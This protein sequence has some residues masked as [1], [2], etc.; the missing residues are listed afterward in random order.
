M[1]AAGMQRFW[2]EARAGALPEG[3]FG[4]LLDARPL[5][6]PSGAKL[7]V[8]ALPLAEEL[9]AEWQHAGGGKGQPF[10]LEALPLTRLVGNAIDRIAADHAAAVATVARY[11]ETDLLCYRADFPPKLAARQHEAWQPL[12]DWA[13]LTFDA[14]LSVTAGVIA[15]RQDPACLAALARAVAAHEPIA[16][17]GLGQVV[18]STGSLVLGLAVSYRRLAPQEAHALAVIDEAFQAEEWGEDAEAAE[19]LARIA[20]DVAAAA[21][22]LALARTAAT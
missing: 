2:A 10:T 18:Q 16:L 4:V 22:L 9:A 13:A 20:A 21:R 3:G 6:L 8:P 15:V 11:G 19:R 12:L 5:R 14:R 17:A 7:S 1:S